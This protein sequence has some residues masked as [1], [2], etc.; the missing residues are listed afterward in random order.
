MA[1]AM[2][3]VVYS[4]GGEYDRAPENLHRATAEH[5][6]IGNR[7]GLSDCLLESA[8]VLLK[9]AATAEEMPDYLPTYVPGATWRAMSIHCAR[10]TAEEC[11]AISEDLHTTG[12]L[13]RVRILLARIEAVEGRTD[14]ALQQL[15]DLLVEATDDEQCAQLH[16]WLWKTGGGEESRDTALRLYRALFEK[17]PNHDYTQRINELAASIAFP[18]ERNQRA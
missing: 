15:T 10:A 8:D 4:R 17:I 1:I 11:G 3:G 9:L 13:L 12:T 6:A 7:D 14:N 18:R 2:I 16:Y 5:R